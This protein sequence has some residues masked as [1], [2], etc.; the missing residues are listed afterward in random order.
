MRLHFLEF[1]PRTRQLTY[2]HRP[3]VPILGTPNTYR[4]LVGDEEDLVDDEEVNG[5]KK[6]DDAL[7]LDVQFNPG[8]DI[9]PDPEGDI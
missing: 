8:D 2:V 3:A 1:E 4:Y 5:A 7:C 9:C 6:A